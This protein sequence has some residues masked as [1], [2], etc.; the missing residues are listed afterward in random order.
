MID[1]LAVALGRSLRFLLRLVRRGGGSALPGVLLARLR[2]SLL[3]RSISRL[4]MG[5]VVIS[6]SAGKSSTT[7]AIVRILRANGVKVFSNPSTANIR[8]GYFSAILT[9]GDIFGRLPYD[10]AVLEVDEGHG[11]SLVDELRPRIAVLTN[12]LSDQLDRFVDPEFVIEKLHKIGQSAEL[13]IL[14]GDDPNLN[15]LSFENIIA[16]G[17]S[18]DADLGPR[19]GY[20]LN[21][22]PAVKLPQAAVVAQL[23]PAIIRFAGNEL[24]SAATTLP[25]ALNDALAVVASAQI[26]DIDWSKVPPILADSSRVFARNE[27]AQIQGR[28][29]NLRLVQNPTSFQ[30][31]LDELSGSEQPLMLMAGADIHDPS[32]LWTV[33]FSDLARVDIVGGS[34]AF[35]LA[36]RLD[37]AGVEIGEVIA[38]PKA[39]A[40]RFLGLPGESPTILFSADAMRRVRRHL[41][42]AK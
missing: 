13:V 34:N 11:A 5:L 20:A 18:K 28:S 24:L 12:V 36:L 7:Q 33:N 8:Q 9:H 30:L 1:F 40:D 39:A 41:G 35:D 26:V 16:V 37:Y 31:N 6:G 2:P 10:I 17:L 3:A 22:N 21:F 27:M 15:Q 38:D 25:H 14:N 23:T 4:P 29:V 32:W 42:L 19:P